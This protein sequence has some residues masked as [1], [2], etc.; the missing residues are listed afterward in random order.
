MMEH[1]NPTTGEEQALP[2]FVRHPDAGGLC[3]HRATVAVYGLDFC[4]PHGTEAKLG[5]DLEASE[6]AGNLFASRANPYAQDAL[7]RLLE[8]APRDGEYHEA[9]VAAYPSPSPELRER[10][11]RWQL[12]EEP[13]YE[14]VVDSLLGSLG[15][16]HKI[17][18]IAYEAGEHGLVEQLEQEREGLAAQA[19]VALEE[20][21]V[22]E[23]TR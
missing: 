22:G 10:V 4:G 15:T 3:Q 2:C 9:L 12:D 18:R 21:H 23:P 8:E 6:D 13:G 16:I 1:T 19:A 11:A 7:H 14:A 17:M 20:E 5:A